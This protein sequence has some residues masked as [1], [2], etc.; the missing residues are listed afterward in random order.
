[1]R[2]PADVL[3]VAERT[4]L[5]AELGDVCLR[6]AHEQAVKW[7]RRGAMERFTVAVNLSAR[8]LQDRR[9]VGLVRQLQ[10]SSGG[11][12]P[13]LEFEITESAMMER[14]EVSQQTLNEFKELGYRLSLD[15]FGTGY[16]SLSYLQRLPIDCI[17]IDRS[18]V[19]NIETSRQSQ[20]IVAATMALARGLSMDVVAEGVEN[21]AQRYHLQDL[22]I[23]FQQGYLFAAALPAPEFE[24]WLNRRRAEPPAL[25]GT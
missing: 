9:V 5:L 16:S 4:G 7:Q 12:V 22:G 13:Y 20:T 18:F 21:S 6:R 14:P 3:N 19:G 23:T 10:A 2:S 1:V 17:K 15:D 25:V 24:A 8:Q 11:D